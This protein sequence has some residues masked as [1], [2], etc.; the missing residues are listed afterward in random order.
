[1]G[2]TTNIHRCRFLPTS[3]RSLISALILAGGIC[4]PLYSTSASQL[5]RSRVDCESILN[6]TNALLTAA[7]L[8]QQLAA[9]YASPNTEAYSSILDFGRIMPLVLDQNIPLVRALMDVVRDERLST[10][11]KSIKNIFLALNSLVTARQL[12]ANADGTFSLLDSWQNQSGEQALRKLLTSQAEIELTKYLPK[13]EARNRATIFS[14][15]AQEKESLLNALGNLSAMQTYEQLVGKNGITNVSTDSL[16]GEFLQRTRELGVET[17]TLVGSFYTGPDATESSEVRR[18]FLAVD[19]QTVELAQEIF[20]NNPHLLMQDHQPNQGTLFLH[21]AGQKVSYAKYDG[22]QNFLNKEGSMAPVIVT[23]SSEASNLTNYFSL[24]SLEKHRA[25]YPHRLGQSSADKVTP[26]C[27]FGGYHSCTHWFGEM[28][29]GDRFVD[30]YSFPGNNKDDSYTNS[31]AG[32]DDPNAEDQKA[33]R[34]GPVGTYDT[35]IQT[36]AVGLETRLDRLTRIVWTQGLGR[37]QM[38]SK[39]GGE[40]PLRAG[41]F[42]NPGW[43]FYNLVGVAPTELVPIVFVKVDRASDPLTQEFINSYRGR[44]SAK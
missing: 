33:I 41:E 10:F 3:R 32:V 18:L 15:A 24:G 19:S 20:G 17:S 22:F 37:E 31:W 29:F 28:A 12:V 21:H 39:V 42:A 25:Q 23:S 34:T 5:Q 2:V 35:Y 36:A 4:T 30:S 9:G 44:V 38:W 26:Y 43:V 40:E 8:D 7:N 6:Q 14:Q 16:V 27:R 1:M 11:H 13:A